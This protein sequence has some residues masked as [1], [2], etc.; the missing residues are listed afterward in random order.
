LFKIRKTL[1]R[2]YYRT[3]ELYLKERL[4]QVKLKDETTNARTIQA[5]VPQGNV[6]GPVLYLIYTSDPQT[7]EKTTA[8]LPMI[9]QCWQHMKNNLI[10]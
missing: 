1:P 4:F 7:L 3:L 5:G 10:L 2:A 8:T 9:Q 6:L